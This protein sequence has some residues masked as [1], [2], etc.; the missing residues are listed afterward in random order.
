M[1]ISFPRPTRSTTRVPITTTPPR[2]FA[3]PVDNNP[4]GEEFHGGIA[5]A[6]LLTGI[7]LGAPIWLGVAAALHSILRV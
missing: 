7:L 3:D 4:E 6:L 2:S 5:W 1:S